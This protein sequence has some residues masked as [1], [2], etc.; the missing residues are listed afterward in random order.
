TPRHGRRWR[1]SVRRIAP[2]AWPVL[3][4]QVAVLLFATIDTILVARYAAVDLAA[5]AIGGSAY[6]TIFVGLM[7]V[8]LAVAPIAGQLFGAGQLHACG[9]ALQQAMWL[10]LAL[11]LPGCALLLFPEP[12]LIISRAQADVGEKVRLHLLGLAF[13]LP[14]ALLFTAFRGFNTAVSRPKVVMA[15]QVS[16]LLLKAPLTALLVFGWNAQGAD[17]AWRIPAFGAPGCGFATAIVMLL[18]ML[19][20]WFVLK[21]DPFYARFGLHHGPGGIGRG[22]GRPDRTRL[23]ELLKLGVP[24]GLSIAIEVTGFTFMA[25]FISRIGATPVAGHQIAVNMVS[26]MFMV[27]LAIANASS[28]LVAQR[29]GANDWADARRIGWHGL[30]VGVLI[31]AA[32]GATVFLLREQVVRLYTH[33][34]IIIGAAVPLLAWVAVFHIADA[35]QTVAAFV[36][37]AYRHATAPL[38]IY[39]LAIWGVGMGGGYWLAFGLGDASPEPL[40]GARGF[41]SAATLGLIL[42]GS[43]MSL[44]L[45]GMMRRQ[46][47]EALAGGSS[48]QTP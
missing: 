25:F 35:A 18:Q 38:V 14:P 32:M 24:M 6:I 41:W 19:A 48:V 47:R 17:A 3:V 15:L 12:F 34:A 39:A 11:S 7:G 28:T 10:A 37:R 29:V 33:D 20:A 36:L 5:L 2:L 4:G 1:D 44:F 45:L 9:R 40:R 27:P 42:A 43:G 30:E 16:A 26:L 23:A 22:L 46:R 13:A 8:V 21:R 31:A